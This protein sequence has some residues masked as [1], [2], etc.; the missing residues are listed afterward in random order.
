MSLVYW[1]RN[2]MNADKGLNIFSCIRTRQSRIC[3]VFA[4]PD[5][6]CAISQTKVQY[7]ENM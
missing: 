6:S 7:R 5:L 1:D 3:I 2:P 4:K